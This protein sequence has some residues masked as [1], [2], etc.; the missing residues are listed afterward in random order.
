[1]DRMRLT[2]PGPTAVE[3]D[4]RR[5]ASADHD[6]RDVAPAPFLLDFGDRSERRSLDAHRAVTCVGNAIEIGSSAG[7]DVGVR[8]GAHPVLAADAIGRQNAP[9]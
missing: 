4:L 1:M 6:A 8:R 3:L 5:D 2:S 9:R 7:I